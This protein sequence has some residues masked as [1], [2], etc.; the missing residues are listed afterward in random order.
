[1]I[2]ICTMLS[3]LYC[4]LIVFRKTTLDS[5]FLSIVPSLLT[6]VLVFFTRNVVISL[7]CG[8]FSAALI[9]SKFSFLSVPMLVFGRIWK[10]LELGNFS[11]INGFLSCEKL[12]LF[13][14]LIILGCVI[15]MIAESGESYGYAQGLS[16][17]LKTRAQAQLASIFLSFTLF[18]DDYLNALTTSSVM[19]VLTDKFRIPRIKLAFLTTAMAAPLCSMVPIS[20]WA[21]AIIMFLTGAGI[22]V[23]HYQAVIIADPFMTLVLSIPFMFF[24][25][26]LILSAIFIVLTGVSYGIIQKHEK[27]ALAD[28]NLFGGATPPEAEIHS[29]Y[30]K[31]HLKHRYINFFAPLI[32]LSGSIFLIM[33][34]TGGFFTKGANFIESLVLAKAEISLLFGAFLSLIFTFLLYFV[35]SKIDIKGGLKACSDGFFMMKDSLIV[36]TLAWTLASFMNSDL[37]SGR[38]IAKILMPIIGK[39]LLP[40][41]AFLMST[42]IAF[43]IGSSWATMTVMFSMVIPMVPAF[44]GLKTPVLVSSVGLIYPVIGAILSGAIF[45]SSLSP[46]SDLLVITSKNTQ[47]NH[48]DY[49]KSQVQYLLPVG[50][51]AGLSF[52]ITGAI[53]GFSYKT[54][55]LASI[56]PGAILTGMIMLILKQFS[57]K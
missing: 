32:V 24:S 23:K 35:Q 27:I 34:A 2:K 54:M 36:L 14:F 57:R 49:V 48:F 6:I 51:G 41:S 38:Y 55:F 13:M 21:A 9:A 3:N 17:R 25:M 8:V 29:S 20:S 19:R 37:Q 50:F 12:F 45:G 47:V 56:F 42:I 5:G 15:A 11:S 18:I 40:F 46:I 10:V 31:N 53:D 52:A 16:N 4:D 33:L 28:G 39:S 44:A 22:T 26:F 43:A 7:L 30:E 1:M